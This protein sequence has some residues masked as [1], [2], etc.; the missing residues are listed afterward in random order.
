MYSNKKFGFFLTGVGIVF[1]F[2]LF[3]NQNN[4][5]LIKLVTVLTFLILLIT[6]FADYV[7]TPLNLIYFS[8]GKTLQKITAPIIMT[9]LFIFLVTPYS[10]FFKLIKRDEL[11]LYK[12]INQHSYWVKNESKSFSFT[13]EF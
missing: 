8:L 11:H 2:I 10:L 5:L 6:I 13:D 9:T 4:S 3:I 1:F 12:K 7:L